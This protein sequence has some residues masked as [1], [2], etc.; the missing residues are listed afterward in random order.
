LHGR[1]AYQYLTGQR[2]G[3]QSR[4]QVDRIADRRELCAAI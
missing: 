2:V 4:R 3:F 1:I